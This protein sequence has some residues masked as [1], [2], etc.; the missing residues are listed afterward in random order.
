MTTVEWIG[1]ADGPDGRCRDCGAKYRL[2]KVG[3]SVPTIEEQ[4][5]AAHLVGW[6]G[7]WKGTNAAAVDQPTADGGKSS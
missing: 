7:V 4:L 1:A 3:D 5:E 2:A 6:F